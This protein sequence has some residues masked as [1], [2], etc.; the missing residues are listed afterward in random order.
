MHAARRPFLFVALALA[1]I[2]LLAAGSGAAVKAR[3]NLKPGTIVVDGTVAK[4][5]KLTVADLAA[6]PQKSLTVTFRSGSVSE[7]HTE[8]G[9][10]LLDVLA[11]AGPTFDPAVKNDKLR[12]Y[13]DATAWDDYASIVAWGEFDPD[14]EAKQI[15]L[16]VE[17]DGKSLASVGPRL[18]VP[19]DIRGGRYVSGVRAITLARSKP[20]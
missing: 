6:L 10:L 3:S 13:V 14:F 18:V 5:L 12:H 7:T 16:S 20:H 4:R 9:P 15:I 2:G 11:L 1:A 8:R 19:G 17:E